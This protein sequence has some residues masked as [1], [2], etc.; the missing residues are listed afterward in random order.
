[1]IGHY[2]YNKVYDWFAILSNSR[3]E[4]KNSRFPRAKRISEEFS[5]TVAINTYKFQKQKKK[6]WTECKSVDSC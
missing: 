2:N 1:M 6:I 4:K 5:F 3:R